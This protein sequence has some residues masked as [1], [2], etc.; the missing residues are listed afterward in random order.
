[1]FYSFGEP[2][3]ISTG[4]APVSFLSHLIWFHENDHISANI[5]P[6]LKIQKLA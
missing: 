5:G 6:I 3:R 2:P 1:M 4:I